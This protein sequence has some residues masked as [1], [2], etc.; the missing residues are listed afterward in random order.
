MNQA[1][2]IPAAELSQLTGLAVNTIYRQWQR[3]HGPLSPILCKLGNRRLGVWRRDY[4]IWV[5]SQRRLKDPSE[6]RTAA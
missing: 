6:Q 5:S 3:N 4:E 1:D 2:F